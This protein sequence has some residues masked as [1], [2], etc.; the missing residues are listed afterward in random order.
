MIIPALVERGR[1]FWL[2]CDYE[3]DSD[4]GEELYSVKWYKNNE[5]FYRLL[6]DTSIRTNAG[7]SNGS[8]ST[9]PNSSIGPIGT[10]WQAQAQS[11]NN[12]RNN[13]Q[14]ALDLNSIQGASNGGSFDTPTGRISHQFFAQLGVHVTVSV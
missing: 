6:I 1:S 14:S 4:K 7:S 10:D 13:N 12:E 3:L 5:E 9:G 11:G 2:S 8:S